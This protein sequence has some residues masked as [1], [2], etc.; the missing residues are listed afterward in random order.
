MVVELRGRVREESGLANR[1]PARHAERRAVRTLRIDLSRRA[2]FRSRA[3][4]RIVR[5]GF[6][7]SERI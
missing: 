2:L 5:D 3:V 1:L 4:D 7:V 6:R